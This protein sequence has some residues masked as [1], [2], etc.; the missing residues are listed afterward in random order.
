MVPGEVT[1]PI[2][3]CGTTFYVDATLAEE[4]NKLVLGKVVSEDELEV[5]IDM[6][7][8]ADVDADGAVDLL[9]DG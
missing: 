8:N 4:A 3:F 6:L 2:R 1:C 9:E 7:V 5:V